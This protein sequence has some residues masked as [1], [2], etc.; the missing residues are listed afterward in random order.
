MRH[1]IQFLL[2]LLAGLLLV[3]S[4]SIKPPE[5]RVTGEMTA[6]EKEVIG[7]YRQIDQDTWMVASTRSDEPQKTVTISPEKKRVLDAKQRQR[8]NQDDVEE[9]KKKGYV[10]ENNQGF[11]AVIDSTRLDADAEKAGLVKTILKEEN[12]DREVIID[13]VIELNESL[14]NAVRENILAIFAEMNQKNSPV[15]TWIQNQLGKWM[16]KAE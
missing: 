12:E 9:F 5:V 1:S 6:L 14:K 4:C 15:G 16:Q 7:T 8:F 2:T 10:G 3:A 13:R 11:L